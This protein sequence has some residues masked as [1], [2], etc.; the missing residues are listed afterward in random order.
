MENTGKNQYWINDKKEH[1]PSHTHQALSEESTFSN[2][3]KKNTIN[4]KNVVYYCASY[5][6]DDIH[7]QAV[8]EK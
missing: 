1:H 4:L 2:Q 3:Q 5:V 6:D 8:V 7:G